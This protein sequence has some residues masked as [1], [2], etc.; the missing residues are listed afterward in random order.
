M[1]AGAH[2]PHG[3][4]EALGLTEAQQENM[5]ALRAEFVPSRG[6]RDAQREEVV[7]LANSG[8]VDGAAALAATQASDAVYQRAEMQRRLAE[9]LTPEQLAQLEH[10]RANGERVEGRR[11]GRHHDQ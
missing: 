5:A 7:A 9:I 11:H 2:P 1:S 10:I 8:D 6:E 4:G 3:L